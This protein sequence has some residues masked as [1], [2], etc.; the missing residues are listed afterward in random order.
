MSDSFSLNISLLHYSHFYLFSPFCADVQELARQNRI[1]TQILEAFFQKRLGLARSVVRP[2]SIDDILPIPKTVED[3]PTRESNHE[4]NTDQYQ[5][6]DNFND[7]LQSVES[8]Q[9]DSIYPDG[10]FFIF[11]LKSILLLMLYSK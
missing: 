3:R 4:T 2:P 11:L 8:E 6:D 5:E 1:T 9:I 7:N 10:I